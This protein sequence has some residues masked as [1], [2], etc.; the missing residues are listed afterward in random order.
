MPEAA[1]APT[2]SAPSAK[3]PC[4]ARQFRFFQGRGQ[5]Q[6]RRESE[7]AER[8]RGE[9]G[10]RWREAPG[11]R[12]CRQSQRGAGEGGRQTAGK[13]RRTGSRGGGESSHDFVIAPRRLRARKCA[14]AFPVRPAGASKGVEKR[15]W[16]GVTRPSKTSKLAQ[17]KSETKFGVDD[18]TRGSR[19]GRG[20]YGA[21]RFARVAGGRRRHDPVRRRSSRWTTSA[22]MSPAGRFAA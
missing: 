8:D 19:R 4:G 5:S 1:A 15:S 2:T 10:G 22:S 14:A 18:A 9:Q 16:K 7:G 6:R 3:G 12:G 17:A 13:A 21:R 20:V 11:Q